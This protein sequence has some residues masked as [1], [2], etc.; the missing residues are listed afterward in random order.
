MVRTRDSRLWR[1][2]MTSATWHVMDYSE[3]SSCIDLVD[4]IFC[5]W[6]GM[7]SVESEECYL[8]TSLKIA[9]NN[10]VTWM[11]SLLLSKAVFDKHVVCTRICF[12]LSVCQPPHYQELNIIVKTATC[13]ANCNLN[14]DQYSPTSTLSYTLIFFLIA[15]FSQGSSLI[16]LLFLIWSGCGFLT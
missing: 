6:S 2:M 3:R 13:F 8:L 1:S 10:C 12:Q 14:I 11:L 7:T 5:R 9:C 15:K 16:G 4:W